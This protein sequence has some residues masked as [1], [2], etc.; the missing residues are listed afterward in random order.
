MHLH[1]CD[2]PLS[3]LWNAARI[4]ARCL[5]GTRVTPQKYAHMQCLPLA[6]SLHL[7]LR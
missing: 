3:G 6:C 7:S 4:A 1:V 2:P 5:I